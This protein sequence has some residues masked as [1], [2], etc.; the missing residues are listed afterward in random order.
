MLEEKTNLYTIR[1]LTTLQSK[2]WRSVII[3]NKENKSLN[4]DSLRNSK[5]KS[6]W[7]I[8]LKQIHNY[9][10]NTEYE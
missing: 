1:I 8:M 10:L 7:K 5:Q 4:N 6:K 3:N 2:Q 9:L